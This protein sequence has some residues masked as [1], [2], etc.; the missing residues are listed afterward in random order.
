M[1]LII[2]EHEP[3]TERKVKHYYISEFIER[4]FFVEYWDLSNILPYLKNTTIDLKKDRENVRRFEDYR[5]FLKDLS[6]LSIDNTVL[7]VEVLFHFKVIDMFKMLRDRQFKWVRINYYH[8]PTNYFNP[9]IS[10]IDKVKNNLKAESI[11]NYLNR[12]KLK[13]YKS[14]SKPTLYFV[15]GS[16]SIDTEVET[17]SLDYF[18]ISEYNRIVSSSEPPVIQGKYIVFLDIMLPNHPDL[19]RYNIKSID[20]VSYYRKL[21]IFFDAIEKKYNKQVVIASHP[22]ANYSNEFGSRLIIA[23]Q[24]ANLVVYSDL[25]ITHGSL[26]ISYALLSKKKLTYIFFDKMKDNTI[27]RF[28]YNRMLKASN[29]LGAGL[30][31]IDDSSSYTSL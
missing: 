19:K 22:K 30:I 10:I 25:V 29:E 5:I 11:I 26:S 23:N 14:L 28:L 27:L 24:T 15:T 31:N 18:D 7:I 3:F 13:R 6:E 2:L 12:C 16:E 9:S 17:V 8:N 21:N 4:G 20:E 1:N